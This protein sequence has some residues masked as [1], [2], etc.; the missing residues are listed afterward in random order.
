MF[1][2]RCGTN[3]DENARF[4]SGCGA[5]VSGAPSSEQARP[6]R[7]TRGLY[8]SRYDSKVAGVCAGIAQ[9]FEIDVA[10]VRILWVVLTVY[11]PG[12]G[13]IAYIIC[14]IAM[15]KEPYRVPAS[16]QTVHSN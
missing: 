11:P 12:V 7:S 13:L 1:C 10:I 2:T 4:C 15:P 14:W 9:H 8:R 3:L 16:A 6:S 5:S